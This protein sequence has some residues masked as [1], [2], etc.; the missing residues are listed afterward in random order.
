MTS[1]PPP[2][3]S[4]LPHALESWTRGSLGKERNKLLSVP[5]TGGWGRWRSGG[6][7]AG[8]LCCPLARALWTTELRCPP[9]PGKRKWLLIFHFLGRGKFCISGRSGLEVSTPRPGAPHRLHLLL[10]QL[11]GPSVSG[12]RRWISAGRL[13]QLGAASP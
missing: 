10:R 8:G 9:L 1:P 3:P 12:G 6:T 13:A 7:P 2:S 5:W 11:R 4:D